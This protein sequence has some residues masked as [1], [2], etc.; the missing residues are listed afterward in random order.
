MFQEC[1]RGQD[2]H[3]HE[4]MKE[5]LG[6]WVGWDFLSLIQSK[7]VHTSVLDIIQFQCVHLLVLYKK[8]T[9]TQSLKT[10]HLPLLYFLI[11][12]V[13]EKGILSLRVSKNQESRH[14]L[15]GSLCSGF[16]LTKP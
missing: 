11:C 8:L 5:K 9:Q 1:Q 10:T 2:D 14:I 7:G 16:R 4:G 12:D 15:T 13:Y 6:Q 3:S